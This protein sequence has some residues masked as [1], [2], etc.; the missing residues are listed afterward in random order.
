MI[1][2]VILISRGF[3]TPCIAPNPKRAKK[4]SR[5]EQNCVV[6]APTAMLVK[7]RFFFSFSARQSG[8]HQRFGLRRLRKSGRGC[9]KHEYNTRL[10]RYGDSS[11]DFLMEER[12]KCGSSSRARSTRGNA[13]HSRPAQRRPER[14]REL[15]VYCIQHIHS[16]RTDGTNQHQPAKLHRYRHRWVVREALW[17]VVLPMF[18]IQSP[19]CALWKL[20]LNVHSARVCYHLVCL[21]AKW[22]QI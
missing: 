6:L 5:I 22:L 10:Q 3:P 11:S 9:E 13:R 8:E 1:G 17:L 12:R 15:P 19:G 7:E 21:I 14:H 4:E 18:R 2:W 16:V 20:K